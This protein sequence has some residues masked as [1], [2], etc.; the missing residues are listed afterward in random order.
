MASS[1]RPLPSVLLVLSLV[2]LSSIRLHFVEAQLSPAPAPLSSEL[3]F[4]NSSSSPCLQALGSSQ[5]TLFAALVQQAGLVPGVLDALFNFG[6]RLTV[7]TPTDDALRNSVKDSALAF[8]GEPDK[9]QDLQNILLS[10]FVGQQLGSA[11]LV[12]GT[13]L[14]TLSGDPVVIQRNGGTVTADNQALLAGHFA[15]TAD[16]FFYELQGVIVPST[17]SAGALQAG[18][19]PTTMVELLSAPKLP[20]RS[21][22]SDTNPTPAPVLTVDQ[23][24]VTATTPAAASSGMRLSAFK[25][26]RAAVGTSSLLGLAAFMLI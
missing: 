26:L 23:K 17:I 22:I 15:N 21:N 19:V 24:L 12:N 14:I 7:M 20:T 4:L 6:N 1:R 10:H 13:M 5:Y 16:C 9:L 11:D 3:L 8:L 2:S 25:S 18:L